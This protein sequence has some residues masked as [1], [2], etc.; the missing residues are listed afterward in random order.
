MH[1]VWP[2]PKIRYQSL[3]EINEKRQ[4]ALVTSG[5]AWE[6][7][8][9]KLTLPVVWQTEV[10]EATVEDWDNLVQDSRGEVVYAVGGGLPFDAGKYLAVNKDIPLIG[11][12][13]AISVDAFMTWASGIRVE[14][15]VRYIET[16]IPSE[17]IVDLD[18]I[19]NAPAAYSGSRFMRF[20]FDRDRSMGLEVCRGAW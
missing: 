20:A 4:V 11:I 12:P 3:E 5:P 15:G 8:R 14:G 2:I 18:V 16:T 1:I 19:A 7:V 6:A 13:T 9:S 17:L 10:I